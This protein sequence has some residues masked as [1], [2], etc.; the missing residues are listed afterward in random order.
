MSKPPPTHCERCG[1]RPVNVQIYPLR[2]ID[3][4]WTCS[5]HPEYSRKATYPKPD[6][7]ESDDQ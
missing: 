2:P 5:R 1:E 6:E 3:G 7:R 4:E